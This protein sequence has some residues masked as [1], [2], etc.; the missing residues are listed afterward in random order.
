MTDDKKRKI[1]SIG[2][3]PGVSGA[4][5]TIDETGK[6]Q[7]IY[8]IECHK[9]KSIGGKGSSE[10]KCHPLNDCFGELKKNNS[11]SVIVA[12]IEKQHAFPGR[13]KEVPGG[14]PITDWEKIAKDIAQNI[15]G[16][17]KK[18]IGRALADVF[19]DISPADL[20]KVILNDILER[21][22][23]GNS[24]YQ[25]P[26]TK[27]VGPVKGVVAAF[28]SGKIYGQILTV[29]C[30]A[31]NIPL[32]AV[33]PA[34][35]KSRAF[36]RTKTS[37]A[38]S[39]RKARA[40]WPEKAHLFKRVMDHDRAEAALIALDGLKFIWGPVLLKNEKINPKT[41]SLPI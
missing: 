25:I 14:P 4:V 18:Y 23:L 38:D 8:D 20:R 15:D 11:D 32:K 26:G 31:N 1:L 24:D 9:I 10:L 3:D 7:E 37:K 22:Y 35:W 17:Q 28:K 19:P 30:V 27:K 29:V 33:M 34:T 16:I 40:L 12:T 36:G 2:I 41:E 5:A 13:Q 39:L 21:F 6:L